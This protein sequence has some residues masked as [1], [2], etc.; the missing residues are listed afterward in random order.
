M[1]CILLY[2]IENL[3]PVE[4]TEILKGATVKLEDDGRIYHALQKQHCGN[5]TFFSSHPS[6]G[7]QYRCDQMF[8]PLLF[9]LVTNKS[10]FFQFEGHDVYD[11]C[12]ANDFCYY[13]CFGRNVG[14]YGT[15]SFTFSRPLIITRNRL[16]KIFKWSY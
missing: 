2:L 7:Y 15:S 11:P 3:E 5:I 9:G 13:E 14:K 1:P 6:V 8:A 10:T 4:K 16:T 12:H